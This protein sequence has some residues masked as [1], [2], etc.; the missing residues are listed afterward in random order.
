MAETQLPPGGS[1]SSSGGDFSIMMMEYQS[2]DRLA[3]ERSA[4]KKGS[5]ALRELDDFLK[6]AAAASAAL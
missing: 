2:A 5:Q 3:R 4:R 6:A 1:S